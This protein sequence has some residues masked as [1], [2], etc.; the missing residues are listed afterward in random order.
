MAERR[1]FA[2]S[3]VDSDA[4]LD[5]PLSTQCLYFHLNERADDDGFVGNAQRIVKLIGAN[6]DDLTLLIAKRFLLSFESGVVVI[7]HWLIHNY[8]RKDRY[9]ETNYLEEKGLLFLDKNNSYTFRDT[10]TRLTNGRPSDIPMVDAGKDS[11]GKYSIG[12]E[13][14]NKNKETNKI[15]KYIDTLPTYDASNNPELDVSRLDE[16]LEGR[17]YEK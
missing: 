3:I 11:I 8:I 2:K 13:S 14:K 1:M 15:N 17:H 4:F 9:S 12:K 16:I 7:K 10:G 6:S 5:M